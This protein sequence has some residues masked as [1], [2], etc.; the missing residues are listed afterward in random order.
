MTPTR[1]RIAGVA[2][3]YWRSRSPLIPLTLLGALVLAATIAPLSRM[4]VLLSEQW[5]SVRALDVLS[6]LPA[7]VLLPTLEAGL[8]EV[9]EAQRRPLRWAR[10]VHVA[11]ASVL[12][13]T[14]CWVAGSVAPDPSAADLQAA[15][16]LC[17]LGITA[18]GTRILRTVPAW[19]AP[20]LLAGIMYF[21]GSGPTG[22]PRPWAWMLRTDQPSL[23]PAIDLA[24][25]IFGLA[26]FVLRRN[27]V[28]QLG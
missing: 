6:V 4:H 13:A 22:S 12:C 14:S 2:R 3:L 23:R 21:L 11:A 8:G 1:T 9:E 16:A 19:V 28:E 7:I 5:I 10:A 15:N 17:F 24:I 26:L 20:V 25:Y 27:V 18:A